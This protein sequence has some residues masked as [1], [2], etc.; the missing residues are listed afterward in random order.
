MM[1]FLFCDSRSRDAE[2]KMVLRNSVS[3]E[4]FAN[5]AFE[6]IL[7]VFVEF[8]EIAESSVSHLSV[9]PAELLNRKLP[10]IGQLSSHCRL[11]D[12]FFHSAR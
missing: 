2:V 5:V 4:T 6:R 8:E 1:I 10:E 9:S 11:I 7:G 3:V 12:G